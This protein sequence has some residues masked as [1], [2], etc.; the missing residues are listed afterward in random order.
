M[1][2]VT[3]VAR[4][5]KLTAGAHMAGK[6]LK[7]PSVSDGEIGIDQVGYQHVSWSVSDREFGLGPDDCRLWGHS[8]GP[9]DRDLAL[10]DSYRVAVV[11]F[12][13]VGNADVAG[14]TDVDG[15]AVHRWQTSGDLDGPDG[16]GRRHRPH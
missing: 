8:A 12:R 10:A 16:I 11:R 3:S 7:C 14:I 9:E 2:L 5:A 4:T 1:S 6:K 13:D 15:G